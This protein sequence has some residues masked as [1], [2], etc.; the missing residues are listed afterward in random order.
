MQTF[1]YGGYCQSLVNDDIKVIPFF[2]KHYVRGIIRLIQFLPPKLLYILFVRGKF[3]VEIAASDGGAAKV[4]SGSTN[5]KSKKICWVHMDVVARGSKL[6][7][8]QNADTAK[9]IYKKFDQIVCVS[10]AC[11]NSFINKFG[12]QYP[13]TVV[14]NP[15]P[16]MDICIKADLPIEWTPYAGLTFV[17][18]GRLVKQK[19]FDR[20]LE[21]CKR[22]KSENRYTFH[23]LIIGS[24]PEQEALFTL[25]KKNNLSDIINFLG[26]KENPYPY[27]KKADVFMLT[28]RDESFSL[29][30]G[31]SLIIGTP[32]IAT[33]CCGIEEWLGRNEQYGFIMENSTEGIY[34]GMKKVL[35]DP[36]A[37]AIFRKNIPQKQCEI[38]FH[39]AMQDFEKILND[40]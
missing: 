29:V 7:E 30:V 34:A 13:V 19:G 18:V 28:S 32:V 22:L 36:S 12:G 24:G 15:M 4:I 33:D 14:Y 31:E 17:C 8:F 9:H 35:D 37:L 26:F 6:K 25:A 16:T 20:L 40:E 23:V 5:S 2:F 21:V 1:W 39:T 11:Q 3:D 10:K 38:D 27:I